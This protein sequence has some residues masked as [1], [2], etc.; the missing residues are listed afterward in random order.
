MITR[1]FLANAVAL[2]LV[3]SA[4]AQTPEWIWHDNKG[5]APAAREVRFF[6]KTFSAEPGVRRAVLMAAGDDQAAVFLNGK[7][8]LVSRSW[9]KAVTGNVLSDLREGENVLAVRGQNGSGDAAVILRLELTGPDRKKTY[10]VTDT[11][12]ISSAE[13]VSG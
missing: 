13:D 12:W 2:F 8:V 6:R 3:S 11:S 5:V 9:N 10:I 7:Q 4:S 1:F